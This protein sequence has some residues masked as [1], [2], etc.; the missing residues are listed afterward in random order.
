MRSTRLMK[1]AAISASC[2]I[3]LFVVSCSQDE[4]GESQGAL[5]I[6]RP[7]PQV[8]TVHCSD[9]WAI[10]RIGLN[11]KGVT[12]EHIAKDGIFVSSSRSLINNGEGRIDALFMRG[13]GRVLTTFTPTGDI[14]L[15]RD[16]SSKSP[17]TVVESVFTESGEK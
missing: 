7:N 14:V 3:S 4:S 16:I 2:I 6:K 12:V 8:V 15:A 10:A 13:E 11:G 9:G 17:V 1:F 5:A